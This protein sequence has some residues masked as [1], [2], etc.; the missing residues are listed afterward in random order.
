MEHPGQPRVC[1]A[2]EAVELAPRDP[3]PSVDYEWSVVQAPA[4]STAETGDG[5]V[6][7]FE[8]DVP[9]RYLLRLDAGGTTHD[10]TV[11]AFA[12][13]TAPDSGDGR[14]A[15]GDAVG[16]DRSGQESGRSGS[17][18]AVGSARHSGSIGGGGDPERPRVH[19]ETAV[20][21]EEVRIDA[22]LDPTAGTRVEFLLDDR[23]DLD[24]SDVTVE[25]G[26]LTVARERLPEQA[27]VY[28]VPLTDDA[29]GVQD[30]VDL[31]R[32]GD[33]VVVDRPYDPPEW[34]LDSTIYE[35]YVRTFA[36]PERGREPFEAIRERLD[37]LDELGVDTL[38]LTPV[39]QHDGEP[40]GY[41]ITDFFEIAADLGGREEYEAL[42]DAAHERGMTVLFDLVCNHSA[43]DHPFFEDA[44]RNPDSEYYDWYEWQ[45]NGEPGTYFD[46]ELIAN[47]DFSSLEVRRHL[48]DAVDEWAPLVDGFRCDMAWAVP[49]GFWTEVHDRVKA[50]DSEFLLLDETI[51]YIPDFQGG[52]FDM[53]FD[54]TTAF[55]LREIG[56]GN[57]PAEAVLDAVDQRRSVGFPD[58]ASF[59]LYHENHDESRY[60]ASYGE[61]AA[62]AS[63]GA[64]ATLPG[65]PMVYAGQETGQLGRRDQL[66]YG[67]ARTDLTEH[68]RRLLALR[69][70]HPALAHRATLS[71]VDYEVAAGSAES[72]VAYRREAADGEAV[73]V[74][75]NFAAGPAEVAVDPAVGTEDLV[76]GAAVRGDDGAVTV[77]D[78]VVVP[79]RG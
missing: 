54:S 4:D 9:G 18:S 63:A 66:D 69:G 46:W 24:E 11:R 75:L 17:G 27:R 74:A 26:T 28:A 58:H 12:Q 47:F 49:D 78:V 35:V 10:L 70:D 38:W 32:D 52:L 65:A 56:A 29:Y 34:A 44:Y 23:D 71:R 39:L 73:V 61:D 31:R 16:D 76:T 5:P 53:H 37:R 14:S 67:N 64:L 3:D 15:S 19:L 22:R 33:E 41:N 51:P 13:G 43:R 50:H 21:D 59:M 20:G 48:L 6:Q 25:G 79:V 72:V 8:P 2:G 68:Y 45:E 30:A 42:V 55:T 62:F 36:D 7:W 77:D 40:H 1:A 57:R 60:L